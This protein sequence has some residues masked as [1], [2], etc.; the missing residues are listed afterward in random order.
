MGRRRAGLAG[1]LAAIGPAAEKRLRARFAA[2]GVDY[3]PASVTLFAGG[4]CS[5]ALARGLGAA[6]AGAAGSGQNALP[7]VPRECDPGSTS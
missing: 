7:A 6:L 1:V 5:S 2:A 4:P 3:P